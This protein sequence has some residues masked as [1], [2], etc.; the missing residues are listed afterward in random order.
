MLGEQS[1]LAKE[2]T[3]VPHSPPAIVLVHGALTDA[4][5][6]HGG[7]VISDPGAVRSIQPE[8]LRDRAKRAG[9][10]GAE[11]ASAHAVPIAH[12]AATAARLLAAV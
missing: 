1:L 10:T 8:A 4:S 12:P 5:A 7:P 9:P 11:P 6:R 3:T 2:N